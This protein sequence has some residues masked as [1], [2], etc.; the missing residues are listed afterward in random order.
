MSGQ[1]FVPVKKHG[2][3][4]EILPYLDL[5][6][7][8]GMQVVFITTYRE[9]VSWME[10]QLTAMQTGTRTITAVT[11]L[12][13]NASRKAH[14][15]SVEEK[16]RSARE[17]FEKKGVT[18]VVDCYSG[19]LRNTIASLRGPDNEMIVLLGDHSIIGKFIAQA[20]KLFGSFRTG[21]AAP[22]LFLRP[23]RQY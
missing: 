17:A 16:V 2:R 5:L 9:K 14:L 10:I 8:P 19:S 6:A 3:I 1:I 20:R 12:A 7:R 15:Q 23:R 4:E 13:A 18:V 21:A 11:A 22:I